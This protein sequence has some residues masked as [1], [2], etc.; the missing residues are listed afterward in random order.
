VIILDDDKARLNVDSIHHWIASSYWSP[1]I[2]RALFERAIAGSHC[3]GAY[4]GQTQV[5][6]ARMVTDYATFAW[7]ADVWVVQEVRGEG[8]G[9]KMVEW[10][11]D[12]PQ[13]GQ[14][15]RM[16]LATRDAQGVYSP[17]GFAVLARPD[18]LME[19]LSPELAD[20]IAGF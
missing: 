6:F 12:H 5:G 4:E 1:G 2:D 9:R 11:L 3:L 16:M 13:I 15:R 18:R 17:L 10:F 8:V 19:R 20:L 7:L 14:V